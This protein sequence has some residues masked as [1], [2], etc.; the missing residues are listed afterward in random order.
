[1]LKIWMFYDEQNVFLNNVPE[2]DW[3]LYSMQRIMV[4]NAMMK[5][6]LLCSLMS[7]TFQAQIVNKINILKQYDI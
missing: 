7:D 2:E 5:W 6:G 4:L 1:M 3:Y